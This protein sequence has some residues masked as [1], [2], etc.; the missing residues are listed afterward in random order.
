[1]SETGFSKT[2]A[3]GRL[4]GT[5]PH[6]VGHDE[7]LIDESLAE[8]FPASDSPS[9]TRPGSIVGMRYAGDR[10]TYGRRALAHFQ[11]LAHSRTAWALLGCSILAALL[12]RQRRD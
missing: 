4:A 12:L 6:G 2:A 9:P 10:H 7:W 1:M 5:D 3:R 8:T 11:A